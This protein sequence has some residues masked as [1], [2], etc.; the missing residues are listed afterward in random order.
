MFGKITICFLYLQKLS[1]F[2]GTGELG[3]RSSNHSGLFP[4]RSGRFKLFLSFQRLH[5]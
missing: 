5:G 3:R 2:S 4:D 1:N